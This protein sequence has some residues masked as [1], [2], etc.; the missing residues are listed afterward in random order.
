MRVLVVNTGS[1]SLKLS[2]LD[3]DRLAAAQPQP[4]VLLPALEAFQTA[5]ARAR[6]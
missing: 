1:S 3:H 4:A 5:P 6:R 2:L